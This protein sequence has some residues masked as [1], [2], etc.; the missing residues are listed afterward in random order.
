MHAGTCLMIPCTAIKTRHV[1][2]EQ[3][4]IVHASCGH[5][6]RPRRV[7]LSKTRIEG[8]RRRIGFLLQ[9]EG[10]LPSSWVGIY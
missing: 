4:V 8:W 9:H 1:H 7:P 2:S 3:A 10:A 5:Y 6:F